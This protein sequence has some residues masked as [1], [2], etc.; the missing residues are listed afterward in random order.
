MRRQAAPRGSSWKQIRQ[1]HRVH[2]RPAD[3]F[4]SMARQRPHE[5]LHRIDNLDPA[6]K[7]DIVD[8][9]LDVYG[10]IYYR[11]FAFVHKH[12][13]RGIVPMLDETTARFRIRTFRI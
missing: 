7:S 5:G 6:T 10:L 3:I 2:Q 9:L 1:V 13:N 8:G 11:V 12:Y 4:E